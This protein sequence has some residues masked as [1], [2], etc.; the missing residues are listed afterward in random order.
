MRN[1]KAI[2]VPVINSGS[3]KKVKFELENCSEV[4]RTQ[5]VEVD[6]LVPDKAFGCFVTVG[7]PDEKAKD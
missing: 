6:H 2:K 3:F 1:R 4:L 5:D 7:L